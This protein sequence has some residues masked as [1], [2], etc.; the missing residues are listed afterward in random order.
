MKTAE[1]WFRECLPPDVAAEAIQLGSDLI[2]LDD[3]T[4]H[5][6][7]DGSFVWGDSPQGHDYWNAVYD[8]LQDGTPIPPLPGTPEKLTPAPYLP[9]QR[10][11]AAGGEVAWTEN[12]VYFSVTKDG[13]IA[14]VTPIMEGGEM[15]FGLLEGDFSYPPEFGDEVMYYA[16]GKDIDALMEGKP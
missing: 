16:E 1:E 9:L 5:G 2:D 11:P 4:P 13:T 15:R 8:A 12:E 6:A 7:L 3:E 14:V 10:G